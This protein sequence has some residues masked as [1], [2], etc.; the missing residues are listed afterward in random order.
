MQTKY[1]YIIYK[2]SLNG[3][4]L[5]KKLKDQGKNVLIINTIGFCGDTITETL[6]LYQSK[7]FILNF[8]FSNKLSFLYEDNSFVVLDPETLKLELHRFLVSNNIEHLF[9]VNIEQ[10]NDNQIELLA[11]EGSIKINFDILVDASDNLDVYRYFYSDYQFTDAYI[12]LITNK[13][14]ENRILNQYD[15]IKYLKLNDIRYFVTLKNDEKN[16]LKLDNRM[17]DILI[18]FDKNIY[19]IRS[20]IVPG[21]THKIFPKPEKAIIKENIFLVQHFEG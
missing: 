18:E 3:I 20:Q 21:N 5:A 7:E 4:K 6:N 2:A 14:L 15:W 10:I 8:P 9:Y 12:H 1:D 17:M 19:P 11:R 16:L 13:P